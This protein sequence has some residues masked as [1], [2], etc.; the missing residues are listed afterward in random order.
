MTDADRDGIYEVAKQSGY[1]KVIFCRMNS[2]TTA[3]N[4]DNKWNQTGDL[5]IPTNGNNCFTVPNGAWDGSTSSWS[6]HTVDVP[7]DYFVNCIDGSWNSWGDDT[8][9]VFINSTS[10][11]TG[12]NA[13]GDIF[14]AIKE[15]QA[16]TYTFK[17][18]IGDK[19]YGN[20]GTID[21][22]TL[23][24]APNGWEMSTSAGDCTLKVTK[25]G[26]Y[27]FNYNTTTNYLEVLHLE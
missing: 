12:I 13:K 14:S 15:L 5:T 2:S 18:H 11:G 23:P 8:T 4:W 25:A 17:V 1:P 27:Q 20:G 10:G 7:V 16:G 9:L 19:W 21:G 22:S 3:N 26:Y 24:G 6:K